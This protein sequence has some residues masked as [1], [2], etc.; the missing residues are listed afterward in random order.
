MPSERRGSNRRVGSD[1]PTIARIRTATPAIFPRMSDAPLPRIRATTILAVR[2]ERQGRARRRRPGDRRRDRHEV[3]RAEGAAA[4]RRQAA[5][6]VRRRRRR[7]LDAVREVRGEARALSGQ[8][9]A[10]RGRAGQGLAQ[11]SR[12]A[13]PRGAARR[14]RYSSTASSSPAPA[15]SSSR[16]T[17]SSR[18]GPAARTRSPPR[19]RSSANTQL[20][21]GGDRASGPA[22]SPA[23]SASTRT[24]TSPCSRRPAL[25]LATPIDASGSMPSTRT[26][27]ALARLADLTPRQIVAELDRYIVGQADAKKAVAIALRNRWRR[28]RAP[29]S[30]PRRDL[31]E[32]HHPHRPDRRREDGDRAAP[33]QAR[34]RAVHQG[35]SVEVHRGRLRRPRRRG[36]GARS[37]RERDRHGAQRARDARSRISRTRRSTS[38]C[39]TCCCRRR[40]RTKPAAARA[41]AGRAPSRRTRRRRRPRR[42]PRRLAAATSQQETGDAAQDRYKRTR[43]KLKQLLLDGQLEAR[44]VEVEV[45]QHGPDVRHVR[46]AGRAGRHGELHRDAPGH[47]AASG[48][49]S[50]R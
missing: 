3:E 9:A 19:A 38:G 43:E 1:T 22:R 50:A 6:R 47:D 46:V 25:G 15:S 8:L 48:R 5:R 45:T 40:R 37:R 42:L 23:R 49:R 30:H 12:A 16:T 36:D 27:Q 39:S 35:R 24:R 14:R 17:A 28:Q 10:R 33:R 32:Q 31:A 41:Q 7:R 21:A 34:R 26:Q 13:P 44:E 29:E 20:D 4:S 2:R 11:R 18:S